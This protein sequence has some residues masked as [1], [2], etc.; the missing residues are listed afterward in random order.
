MSHHSN[1]GNEHRNEQE[2]NYSSALPTAEDCADHYLPSIFTRSNLSDAN[3]TSSRN[4]EVD[5]PSKRKGIPQRLVRFAVPATTNLN[6]TAQDIHVIGNGSELFEIKFC[7]QKCWDLHLLRAST[8]ATTSSGACPTRNMWLSYR[9][10]GSVVQS[11]IFSEDNFIPM[12]KTFLIQSS[13]PELLRYFNDKKHATL[14]IYLCTEGEVLGTSF[15]DLRHLIAPEHECE[16]RMVQNEYI[17]KSRRTDASKIEGGKRNTPPFSPRIAVRL[18]IDRNTVIDADKKGELS[19]EMSTKLHHEWQRSTLAVSSSTSSQTNAMECDDRASSPRVYST[20]DK[21]SPNEKNQLEVLKNKEHQL[22]V[23]EAELSLREKEIYQAAAALERKRCEWEQWRCQ[24]EGEWQEKLRR[25]EGAMLKVVEERA[26]IIEKER[27]SSLEVSKNE[28]E[29]LEARLRKALVDVET[30]ERQLKDT[31]LGHQHERKRRLAELQSREKLMKDDLKHS[32]EIERAKANAAI[33]QAVIAGKAAAVANKKVDQMVSEMDQLREQHRAT[34]E[35]TLLHQLAELKGQLADSERRIE[36]LK[37]EKNQVST[38][39]EQF[40]SSVHKLARALRLEREKAA[41]KNQCHNQQVRLSY[42]INEQ[43][44][45]LGGEQAEIQRIL[46]DLCKISQ[47]KGQPIASGA[48]DDDQ[49]DEV[50]HDNNTH[51]TPSLQPLRPSN[52]MSTYTGHSF[53]MQPLIESDVIDL[54]GMLPKG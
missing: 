12:I 29:K 52:N 5:E 3:D 31:E 49:N 37:A 53:E 32:I 39:K 21:D 50:S 13:L 40:R 9:F 20:A 17:I 6:P 54:N 15:V 44:F 48:S 27:L 26:C 23:K 34:P 33:E 45:V 51:P 19:P 1:P 36:V 38:E 47:R 28:Y 10:I 35:F 14:R 24:Q 8:N 16:G 42:D 41:A 43:S 22:S 11:E 7:V 46:A 30:K 18:C 25:K 2:E 4:E